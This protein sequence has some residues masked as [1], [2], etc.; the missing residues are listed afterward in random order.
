MCM[1][2]FTVVIVRRLLASI[3]RRYVI[4][5]L[6]PKISFYKSTLFSVI[7]ENIETKKKTKENQPTNVIYQPQ[8]PNVNRIKKANT[9]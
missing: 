4:F 7:D 5:N 3:F 8:K 1:W 9:S 6:F 2:Y